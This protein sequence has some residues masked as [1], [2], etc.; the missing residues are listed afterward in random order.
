MCGAGFT[1]REVD[2]ADPKLL[3]YVEMFN[4]CFSR[5]VLETGMT[6]MGPSG[7][8]QNTHRALHL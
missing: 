7:M 5:R 6:S 1:A 3:Q 2:E 8:L 4:A